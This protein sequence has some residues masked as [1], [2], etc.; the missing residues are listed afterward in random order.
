MVILGIGAGVSFLGSLALFALSSPDTAS[1]AALIG[2]PS[3]ALLIL[4]GVALF[5]IAQ[6]HSWGKGIATAVAVG[7][8]LTCIGAVL[9]IP[10]L[11]ALWSRPPQTAR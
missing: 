5:A 2:L 1:T 4:Q 9:G 3:V 10:L 11:I 7:W 8:C 6:G